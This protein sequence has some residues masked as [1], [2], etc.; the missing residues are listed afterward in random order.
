MK[1]SRREPASTLLPLDAALYIVVGVVMIVVKM[2][3][4]VSQGTRHIYCSTAGKSGAT[5]GEQGDD[6]D[7]E[8]GL[9][10]PGLWCAAATF[11]THC[12]VKQM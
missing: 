1:E 7:R 5:L 8:P 11:T 12:L 4:W 2:S 3:C 9:L 10:G 6:E